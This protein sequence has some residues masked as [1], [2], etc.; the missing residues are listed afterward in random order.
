MN[1]TASSILFNKER[2][3]VICGDQC[4]C[5]GNT[6]SEFAPT[7]CGKGGDPAKSLKVSR[8]LA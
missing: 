6:R 3:A 5:F 8:L 4:T 1:I 7:S 2:S